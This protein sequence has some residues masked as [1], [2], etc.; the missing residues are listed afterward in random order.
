MVNRGLYIIRD[1]FFEDFP[2]PYLKTNKYENRPCYFCYQ[3]K[4]NDLLWMIPMSKQIEKYK[5]IIYNKLKENKPC[6]ILHV[7]KLDNGQE[8]AFLIQ[9]MFPIIDT[10]IL[11][12]YTINGS[13]LKV[14][15]DALAEVIEKKARTVIML[16]R[17]GIKFSVK[18][19]DVLKIE[20]AL[21]S[22][23]D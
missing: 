20:K 22:K 8:S 5:G 19:P 15:S 6:D 11:K 3:E 10:Y 2:D 12:E 14:T 17:K 7:A 13:I 16:I 23:M 1:K 21:L 4:T 18:Q 9:D